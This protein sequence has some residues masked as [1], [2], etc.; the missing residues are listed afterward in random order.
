MDIENMTES[1]Y[2]NHLERKLETIEEQIKE[3][4]SQLARLIEKKSE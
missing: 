2:R 1:Q 4:V 3:I